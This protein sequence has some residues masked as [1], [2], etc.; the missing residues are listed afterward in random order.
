MKIKTDYIPTPVLIL[1]LNNEI[2]HANESAVKTFGAIKKG[3]KCFQ[4]THKNDK[5]CNECGEICPMYEILNK[6]ADK[7]TTLH[8]HKSVNGNVYD[9]VTLKK[10][11]DN[12]YIE[13]M[14]DITDIF[15]N[16]LEN[17]K[18]Q[19]ELIWETDFLTDIY[20]RRKII[21]VINSE[22]KK[23]KRYKKPLTV[24]IID[25]DGFKEINDSFGH[26]KGD[27]VLRAVG[28]ILKENIRDVDCAGR[29]GG[30]EFLLVLPETD[31]ENS[32]KIAKRIKKDIEKMDCLTDFNITASFGITSANE[33]DLTDIDVIKRA[34]EAL[35]KSKHDGKNKYS[36]K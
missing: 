35:Y 20:N 36:V 32:L 2:V 13:L 28:V 29:Y 9:I 17:N 30:D 3:T 12:L 5:P 16:E 10:I 19:L 4:Y 1:N 26:I 23:S 18:R 22:L 34:D 24:I 21:S 33:N 6:N 31:V 8:I 11:S 15:F 27:E 7:F 14:E 25:L